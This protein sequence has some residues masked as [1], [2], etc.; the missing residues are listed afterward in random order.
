MGRNRQYAPKARAPWGR[1]LAL[2]VLLAVG[3]AVGLSLKPIHSASMTV[4]AQPIMGS[5]PDSTHLQSINW[6]TSFV[7]L[8]VN[9]VQFSFQS[10][11]I[12]GYVNGVTV[13]GTKRASS[14]RVG[15]C[16]F[17]YTTWVTVALK[18]NAGGTLAT[19]TSDPLPTTSGAW[20]KTM[21]LATTYYHNIATVEVSFTE[22][23]NQ[24][25]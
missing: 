16:V 1:L 15:Q 17:S 5:R 10:P 8:T 9:R 21:T 2:G 24:F 14:R 11:S 13:S 22:Q 7:V 6:S 18:D 19:A 12:Q 23:V 20:Q 25:C 3:L 4:K